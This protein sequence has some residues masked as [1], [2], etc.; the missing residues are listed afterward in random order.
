MG[1]CTA[2]NCIDGR[3]QL[4]VIRFLQERFGVEHVDCITEPGPVRIFDK[5][6]DL[7]VLNSIFT[8]VNISLQEHYSTGVAICAH[9]DCTGNPADDETQQRQLRRA[10]IFLKESY[11]DVEVIALWV[12]AKRAVSEIV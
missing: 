2:I 10:V 9:R 5:A 1:F 8:R 4:P 3:V 7:M 6:A 11:P 12:D